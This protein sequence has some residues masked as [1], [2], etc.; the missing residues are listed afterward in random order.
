MQFQVGNSCA[1]SGRVGPRERHLSW[2]GYYCSQVFLQWLIGLLETTPIKMDAKDVTAEPYRMLA[3]VG[4]FHQA[5]REIEGLP[6]ILGPTY[7]RI[8]KTP[9]IA[10]RVVGLSLQNRVRCAGGQTVDISQR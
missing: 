2:S 9:L 8:G 6:E 4:I 3:T 7:F 1:L 10:D 5:I